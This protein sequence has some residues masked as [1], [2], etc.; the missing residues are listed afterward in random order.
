MSWENVSL[1]NEIKIWSDYSDS[2]QAHLFVNGRHQ[3]LLN[4]GITF[5]LIDA[6]L[7]GPDSDEVLSV[8]QLINN[9]DSGSLKYLAEVDKGQYDAVFDPSL[10]STAGDS[11]DSSNGLYDYTYSFYV[12]SDS[13][14]NKGGWSES[15]ALRL[16]YISYR[17]GSPQTVLYETSRLG[18]GIKTNV[19]ICCYPERLYGAPHEQRAPLAMTERVS[20]APV[21]INHNQSS[22]SG[23]HSNIHA[24]HIDDDYF[25][26]IA[27]D[28]QHAADSTALE[29]VSYYKVQEK[30]EYD[31][32]QNTHFPS[33][34]PGKSSYDAV[35]NFRESSG[36]GTPMIEATVT[37]EQ[38]E[39]D[40]NFIASYYDLQ[41]DDSGQDYTGSVLIYFY[42][43]F[44]NGGAALVNE[45]PPV[46]VSVS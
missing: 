38:Q 42:D 19:L 9:T 2:T 27:F 8:L 7:P 25:K 37:V 23:F 40:I 10:Q 16:D 11:T 28:G 1:I 21:K 30:P 15:V 39:G 24:L 44:G 18:T 45:C 43:Q 31:Q 6:T 20:S 41:G 33:V 36:S 35:I 3:V 12:Q 32:I 46:I 17:N 14:I 5:E 34:L 4:V 29:P 22:G 26:I 13:S